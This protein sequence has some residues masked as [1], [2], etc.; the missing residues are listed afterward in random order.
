MGNSGFVPAEH[1]L[2]L[3]L[4]NEVHARTPVGLAGARHIVYLTVRRVR[5]A[6][7]SEEGAGP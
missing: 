5:R 7:E 1:A 6:F 4:N 3:T 2:R